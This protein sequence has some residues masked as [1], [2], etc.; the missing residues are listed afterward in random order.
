MNRTQ[1]L[2]T[3]LVSS[4]LLVLKLVDLDYQNLEN[5]SYGWI[6]TF[7][8]ILIAMCYILFF[9]LNKKTNK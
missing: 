3:I 7:I 9:K 2:S 5:N 4:I 6:I 1:V 8:V